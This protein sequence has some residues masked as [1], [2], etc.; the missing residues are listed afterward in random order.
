MVATKEKLAVSLRGPCDCANDK[1][2]FHGPCQVLRRLRSGK[3][4]LENEAHTVVLV[5]PGEVRVRRSASGGFAPS[6]RGQ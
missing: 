3:L 4:L 1:G 6:R 2:C 5:D